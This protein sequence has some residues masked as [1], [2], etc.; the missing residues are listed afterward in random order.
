[1]TPISDPAHKV[2]TRQS[3][4]REL[5]KCSSLARNGRIC[6]TV[7]ADGLVPTLGVSE[8]ALTPQQH[9]IHRPLG[10]SAQRLQLI[11]RVQLPVKLPTTTGFRT[12]LERTI[13][14]ALR[15]HSPLNWSRRPLW[16]QPR[17]QASFQT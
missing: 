2:H 4:P 9:H 11:F 6:T 8:A 17:L 13:M 1:M 16:V 3:L 12:T 10:T 15:F 14:R 7:A 5:K